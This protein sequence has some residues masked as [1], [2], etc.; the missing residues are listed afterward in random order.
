[1]PPARPAALGGRDVIE[2]YFMLN[3]RMRRLPYF[4]YSVLLVVIFAVLVGIFAS[5]LTNTQKPILATIALLVGVFLLVGWAGIALGVKRCHDLDRSGW[6]YFWLVFVPGALSSSVSIQINGATTAF[7]LPI[8][9]GIA[10][11]IAFIGGMYLLFARGTD[12]PNKYGY[13]PEAQ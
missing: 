11:V 2:A 6:L 10:G 7:F 3:G 5:Q 13:P 8:V 4:G 9:G 12:G 1:M